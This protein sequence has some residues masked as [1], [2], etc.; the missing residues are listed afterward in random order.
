[1]ATALF[2]PHPECPMFLKKNRTVP[3]NEH[4]VP[5][6]LLMRESF[7]SPPPWWGRMKERRI[8]RFGRKWEYDILSP[9]EL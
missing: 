4:E 8:K 2:F 7:Q 5:I 3:V 6:C 9:I 1:M